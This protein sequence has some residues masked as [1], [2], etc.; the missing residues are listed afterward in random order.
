MKRI[1]I[2]SAFSFSLL[3]SCSST[4]N[5]TGKQNEGKSY[6]N[7]F[8][9][10]NTAD[11]EVRVRLEKELA[12]AVESKEYTAIKSI[13]ILP[14]SL[15]DPKPPPKEEFVN[16]VKATG[17]DALFVVYFLKNGEEVR[18]VP[19]V[20][21]KGTEPMLSGLVGLLLGYKD[22]NI[23]P[24][25]TKYKKSIS[26]PGFYTKEKVG[27]YIVSELIDAASEQIIYSEKSERFDEADL[28]LFSRGYM[29]N[30]VKHLE[31]K[32]ILRK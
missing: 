12:I 28:V 17:C 10:A 21:F 4:K 20:N 26:D 9:I 1:H 29:T 32:K 7:L 30:L 6:N 24:D 5:S 31:M 18:H 8:I 15:N 19:G 13:D 16:K 11:I 2:F 14:I 22:Y 3:L 25:D 23:N 27:F